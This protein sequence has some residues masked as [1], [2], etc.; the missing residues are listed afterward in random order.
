MNYGYNNM[1]SMKNNYFQYLLMKNDYF[2]RGSR[3]IFS[4]YEC[5][6]IRFGQETTSYIIQNFCISLFFL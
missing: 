3:V 5:M 4:K 2:F 1:A 6:I